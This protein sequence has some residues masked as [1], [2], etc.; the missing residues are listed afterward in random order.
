MAH[1]IHDAAP[2]ALA[3]TIETLWMFEQK[4]GFGLTIAGLLLQIGLGVLSPMMPNNG[5]G[6]ERYP[7]ARL[8]QTPT[9]VDVVAGFSKLRV[10][11]I[12]LLECFA[13]KRHV[14]DRDVLSLLTAF[15]HVRGLSGTCRHTSS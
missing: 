2:F 11:T 15:Q 7:F 13:A 9:D 6:R 10:K 3:A 1:P 14:A 8:L 12:N 5:A 4:Q